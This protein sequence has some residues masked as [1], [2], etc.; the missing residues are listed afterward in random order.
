MEQKEFWGMPLNT[1][2][3]LIHLAQLSSIIAPGFGF[4]L[5]VILWAANKDQDPRIDEHGKVTINWIISCLI[6][7]ALCFVLTFFLI[8][9][10]GFVIIAI[11]NFLF[12]I[13]AAIKANNGEVWVYPFSFK[14]LK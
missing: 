10:L 3:M 11:M 2:C 14:F 1:Y 12:A 13:I 9:F 6:Y 5:P 8:G 4:I 7:T